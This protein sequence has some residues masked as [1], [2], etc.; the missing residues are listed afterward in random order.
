MSLSPEMIVPCPNCS[1]PIHL[2]FLG[3]NRG[4]FYNVCLGCHLNIFAIDED[5]AW[6]KET[7]LKKNW[8]SR[9]YWGNGL[10]RIPFE[11]H[12]LIKDRDDARTHRMVDSIFKTLRG[13]L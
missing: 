9:R 11:L 3:E 7:S 5:I 12:L 1:K 13:E 8:H 6:A 2:T 4:V 10:P